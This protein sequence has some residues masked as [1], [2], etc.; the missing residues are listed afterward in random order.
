MNPSSKPGCAIGIISILMFVML[1]SW[2]IYTG[3]KQNKEIDKFTVA[4]A[5]EL[6]VSYSPADT[7]FDLKSRVRAFGA[8][9][10]SGSGRLELSAQ[11]LNDLIGHEDAL[12]DLR[13]VIMF[14]SMAEGKLHA[15]VSLPMKTLLKG[16]KFRYLNGEI[17][18]LPSVK[19]GNQVLLEIVRIT[20]DNGEPVP[21]GFLDFFSANVNLLAAYR[22]DERIGPTLER[23]TSL[24][25]EGDRLIVGVQ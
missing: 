14:T 24:G 2:T 11:D 23:I 10:Q 20:P 17:Q 22:E 3:Y 15:R 6:P 13:K 7:V 8:A 1:I 12:F 5:I 16:G 25:V 18:F 4:E 9:A 21:Q 19:N